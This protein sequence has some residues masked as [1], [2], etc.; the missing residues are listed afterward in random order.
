MDHYKKN[1]VEDIYIYIYAP[2]QLPII[3][4][5][6]LFLII[7]NSNNKCKNLVIPVEFLNYNVTY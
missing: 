6:S 4:S 1:F 5:I 2:I 7:K 3:F